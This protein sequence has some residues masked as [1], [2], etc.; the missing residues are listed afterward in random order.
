MFCKTTILRN[1]EKYSSFIST[2][3]M[4]DYAKDGGKE[5]ITKMHC[6]L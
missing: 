1:L 2:E 6:V 4:S 3:A 5:L